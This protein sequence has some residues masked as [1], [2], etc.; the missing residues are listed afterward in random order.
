MFYSK[1]LQHMLL[2]RESNLEDFCFYLI[3]KHLNVKF[4]CE[5]LENKHFTFLNIKTNK[6]VTFR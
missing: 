6:L 4:P 1:F 2:V 3:T 5:F